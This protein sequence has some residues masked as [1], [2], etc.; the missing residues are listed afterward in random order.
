M[1]MYECAKLWNS[2]SNGIK[3]TENI[4]KFK[5]FLK[6]GMELLAYLKIILFAP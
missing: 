3:T 4:S 1:F 5:T 6:N 2:I